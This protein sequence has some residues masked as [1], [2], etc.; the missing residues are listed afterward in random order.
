MIAKAWLGVGVVM[1]LM[2]CGPALAQQ[3][4]EVIAEASFFSDDGCVES[5]VEVFV[6][7]TN[8]RAAPSANSVRIEVSAFVFDNCNEE[9]LLDTREKTN[10]TRSALNVDEERVSLNATV[11]TVDQITK[12]A[13]SMELALE[14]MVDGEPVVAS[15]RRVIESRGRFARADRAVTRVLASAV[16]S[17]RVASDGLDLVDGSTT[18]A[19]IGFTR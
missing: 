3:A 6:R 14:W 5:A 12:N 10:L 17:G 16:A 19:S 15:T 2:A 18:D 1:S 13:L 8:L 4:R 9:I 7:D 11:P